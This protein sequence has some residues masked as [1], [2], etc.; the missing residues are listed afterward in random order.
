MHGMDRD[1][2]CLRALLPLAGC[3]AQGATTDLQ[4]FDLQP[5]LRGACGDHIAV[6]AVVAGAGTHTQP[7]RLRPALEQMIKGSTAGPGHEIEAAH[8]RLLR[9]LVDRRTGG[10]AEES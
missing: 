1:P 2:G 4:Y 7:P 10:A 5:D 8:A 3:T 6:T 9:R